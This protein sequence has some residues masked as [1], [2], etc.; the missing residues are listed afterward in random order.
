M[1]QINHVFSVSPVTIRARII[2]V[3]KITLKL[4]ELQGTN[5]RGKKQQNKSI[6][7]NCQQFSRHCYLCLKERNI[8]ILQ[9]CH[10]IH[11]HGG[12]ENMYYRCLKH[13]FYSYFFRKQLQLFYLVKVE[14][15][16]ERKQFYLIILSNNVSNMYFI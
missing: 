15:E 16:P 3:S 14:K 12:I 4:K 6:F 10:L 9:N 13:R 8:C 7:W 5:W 1:H 11:K 2:T